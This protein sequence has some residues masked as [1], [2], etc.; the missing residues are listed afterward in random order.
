MTLPFS[1]SL[2]LTPKFLGNGRRSLQ[3]PSLVVIFPSHTSQVSTSKQSTQKLQPHS[4][5]HHDVIIVVITIPIFVL[6][7][8]VTCY[9]ESLIS[10]CIYDHTANLLNI[11]CTLVVVIAI[12]LGRLECKHALLGIL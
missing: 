5:T 6:F 8:N 12:I 11:M 2:S 7:Y 1:L 4:R 9:I 3:T 10:S